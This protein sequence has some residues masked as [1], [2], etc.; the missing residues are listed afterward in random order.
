MLFQNG[1]ELKLIYFLIISAVLFGIGLYGVLTKRHL[2][3]VL[4]SVELILNAVLINLVAF[5]SFTTP[6]KI[7]GQ[8]FAVFVIVVAACEVG[9]GLAIILSVYRKKRTVDIN[10]VNILKW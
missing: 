1:L 4:L 6:D 9:V 10:N 3:H 8:M 2:I 7:T 5:S